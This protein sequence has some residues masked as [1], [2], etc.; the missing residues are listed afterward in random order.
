MKKY[1]VTLYFPI[2][3]DPE[4]YPDLIQAANEHDAAIKA[5]R[6][7]HEMNPTNPC[8]GKAVECRAKET[9]K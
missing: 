4:P 6:Y 7:Y 1:R 3:G 2:G 5:A 8:Y 9:V